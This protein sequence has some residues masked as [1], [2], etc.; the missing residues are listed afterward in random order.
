MKKKLALLGGK[1][2]LKKILLEP[3]HIGKQEINAALEVL[4][5]GILSGFVAR[6]NDEFLG[7]RW[8]RKLERKFCRYF[9]SEYAVS[10]NSATSCLYAA[11]YALGIC[12]GDE[13]IVSPYT[14]SATVT[15]ILAC[16]GTPVFADVDVDNYCIDADKIEPLITP[17][18]KAIIAVH[19]FGNT[20]EMDRIMRIA[21]KYRL[22]VIEDCAQAPGAAFKGKLAGRF[23]DIG[24]FSLNRHKTIQ[25]GEGGVALTDC[26]E[27]ALKLRLIRNH[28]EDVIDQMD[29]PEKFNLIGWNYKMTELEAAIATQQLN[30]LNKLNALRIKMAEYLTLKLKDF[31]WI[32]PNHPTRSGKAVY[33]RYPLRYIKKNLGIRRSTL[34]KALSAEGFLL[35]EGYVKPI[36]L[37]SIY[38]KKGPANLPFLSGIHES[39]RQYK[40]GLCPVA[41]K[42]Y[43]DELL[44]SKIIHCARSFKGIDLFIFALKK[45]EANIA[46]LIAYE[47]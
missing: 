2:V 18:T 41:E 46:G 17:K 16:S 31:D 13:V 47:K 38:K 40:V 1:P 39:S 35:N 20:A 29:K 21:K 22:G 32:I 14:M 23:G 25:C 4:A 28:G 10:M 36:Y 11:V 8:V 5:T 19:L 37:Q 15:A 12:P 27:L 30:K 44:I 43:N 7:G 3:H 34:A 6:S 33:Y 45:I 26:K 9:G 24:V 42:L